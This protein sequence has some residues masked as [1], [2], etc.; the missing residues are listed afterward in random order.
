MAH[1]AKSRNE[2][3]V[4]RLKDF[5]P[6]KVLKSSPGG[7][8]PIRVIPE[9]ENDVDGFLL[10][11]DRVKGRAA[12]KWLHLET[13]HVP[14][15]SFRVFAQKLQRPGGRKELICAKIDRFI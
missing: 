11:D 5:S 12:E 4:S 15:S 7:H 3:T 9:F 13:L 6:V 14:K 8:H 10:E 1:A 2:G